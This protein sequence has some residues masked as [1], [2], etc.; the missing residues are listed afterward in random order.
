MRGARGELQEVEGA[1]EGAGGREGGLATSK[2]IWLVLRFGFS[3]KEIWLFL[4]FGFSSKE[5]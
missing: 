4:R 2:E 5:I 3:S 1:G